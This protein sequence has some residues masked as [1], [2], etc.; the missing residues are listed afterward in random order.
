MGPTPPSIPDK[1]ICH[2]EYVPEP[3]TS[4]GIAV[5]IL[6]EYELTDA[7]KYDVALCEIIIVCD[8]VYAR[9]GNVLNVTN[10]GRDLIL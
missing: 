9:F 6:S 7:I 3:V 8:D 5:S 2:V 1:L 4:P 10:C